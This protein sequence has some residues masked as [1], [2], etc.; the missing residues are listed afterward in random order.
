MAPVCLVIVMVNIL[1]KIVRDGEVLESRC[2]QCHLKLSSINV[3]VLRTE[4]R[5]RTIE[6]LERHADRTRYVELCKATD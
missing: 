6:R 4:Y 2:Y 3:K 5:R 1:Y